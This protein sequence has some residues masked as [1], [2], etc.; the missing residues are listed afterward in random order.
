MPKSEVTSN[1]LKRDLKKKGY[2][3]PSSIAEYIWNG[4][5]AEATRVD[6]SGVNNELGGIVSFSITDNGDGI[7]N[8]NS[9]N[10]LFES[11]KSKSNI[12][13]SGSKRHGTNNLGN[14][15]GRLTFF[16]FAQEATWVTV[17]ED[18]SGIRYKYKIEVDS[19]SLVKW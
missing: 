12:S 4:F 9:F 11:A 1:G 19:S 6:V 14:S 17:Y 16:T 8:P 7:L 3:P 18:Q 15:L 2:K 5:D 10:P 13:K